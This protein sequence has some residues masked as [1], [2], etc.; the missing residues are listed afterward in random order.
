MDDTAQTCEAP[1]AQFALDEQQTAIRG[2]ALA[3]ARGFH[4]VS[5]PRCG[6]YSFAPTLP[7]PLCRAE[8]AGKI[9]PR[10]QPLS[11]E[12][13]ENGRGGADGEG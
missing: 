13:A 11:Q 10:K 7:Y 12:V 1:T 2:M 5:L 9:P 3:F 8:F 4:I 6:R